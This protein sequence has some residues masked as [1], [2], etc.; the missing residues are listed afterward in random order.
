VYR[1]IEDLHGERIRELKQEIS[2]VAIDKPIAKL[3]GAKAGSPALYVLRYYIGKG[4]ALLSV[5]IN[6]YPQDRF[7]LTT[8]WRLDRG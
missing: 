8:R 7:K 2:C 6:I 3:L 5:S 4:G 1:L